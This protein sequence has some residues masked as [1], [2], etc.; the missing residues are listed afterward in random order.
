M[1]RFTTPF[2]TS[3][4]GTDSDSQFSTVVTTK[5]LEAVHTWA[6]SV[7]VS[8]DRH[9]TMPMNGY[10]NK[11]SITKMQLTKHPVKMKTEFGILMRVS[12]K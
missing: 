9:G 10:H 2:Q 3:C 1:N 5:P 12:V 6:H 11:T 4:A 7:V 8:M